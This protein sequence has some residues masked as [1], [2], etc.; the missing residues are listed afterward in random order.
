MIL[1][2]KSCV[3]E[4]KF[5]NIDKEALANTSWNEVLVTYCNDPNISLGLLLKMVNSILDKLVSLT[6]ITKKMQKTYGKP[7]LTK[8]IMALTK[9]EYTKNFVKQKTHIGEMCYITNLKST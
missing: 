2:K 4:K 5:K 3:I 7:W 1:I 6:R 9:I 8:G